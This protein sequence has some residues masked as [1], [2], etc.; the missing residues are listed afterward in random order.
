MTLLEAQV[1]VERWRRHY[2][3]IRPHSSLGYKP[4]APEVWPR[5]PL[6]SAS[7]RPAA[8]MGGLT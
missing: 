1:L 2:N 7:L 5:L 3:T 4:P 6:D 8:T